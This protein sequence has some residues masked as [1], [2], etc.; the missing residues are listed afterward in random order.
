MINSE[1]RRFKETIVAMTN[2]SP[3][4]IEVKRMV[5]NEICAAINEAANNAVMEEQR[6]LEEQKKKSEEIEEDKNE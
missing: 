4:P 6:A 1:I 3:L 2:T 5:F